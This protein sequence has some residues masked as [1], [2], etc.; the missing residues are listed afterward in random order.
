M[1]DDNKPADEKQER[2][3]TAFTIMNNIRDHCQQPPI[4]K[5]LMLV[6]ATYANEKGLCYPS[7]DRL[8]KAIST[9]KRTLQRMLKELITAGEIE[10]VS[11]GKGGR[12]QLR[13]LRLTRYVENEPHPLVNH[14]IAL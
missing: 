9:S 5:L 11:K 7:N 2:K 14:D 3:R 4:K 8:V 12:R 10:L 6:L 13:V 1:T